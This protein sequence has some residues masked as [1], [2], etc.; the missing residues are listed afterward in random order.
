MAL[1]Q[2]SHYPKAAYLG[3]ACPEPPREKSSE[4]R[5]AHTQHEMFIR[6]SGVDA[7]K[8]VVST[9]MA[10]QRE[11]SS[12]RQ[13]LKLGRRQHT[14]GIWNHCPGWPHGRHALDTRL[15]VARSF[16]CTAVAGITSKPCSLSGV[17]GRHLHMKGSPCVVL[18]CDLCNKHTSCT[19]SSRAILRAV[20]TGALS[21]V[22]MAHS[23]RE[24]M[25]S[26]L[27][28]DSMCGK[29]SE[30]S[31]GISVAIFFLMLQFYGILF[32]PHPAVL[33]CLSIQVI[34]YYCWEITMIFILILL[35]RHNLLSFPFL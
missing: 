30:L 29:G 31:D 11:N 12:W 5:F 4:L 8:K 22:E 28:C 21:V 35:H 33:Q 16:H 23:G 9:S 1:A 14:R 19:M 6:Y 25:S 15:A 20:V 7:K 27:A 3:A 34:P 17:L 18:A 10:L 26:D 2:K 32:I 24:A 13:R